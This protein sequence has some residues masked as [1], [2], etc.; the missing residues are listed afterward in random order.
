MGK[1]KRAPWPPRVNNN[2]VLA[3]PDYKYRATPCII[4]ARTYCP[5]AARPGIKW[6]L[7]RDVR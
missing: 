6:E 5:C 3:Q 7:I 4:C 2:P 1:V